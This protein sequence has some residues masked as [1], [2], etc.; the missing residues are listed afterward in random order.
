MLWI[1]Q[2]F[3]PSCFFFINCDVADLIWLP[4]IIHKW[5]QWGKLGT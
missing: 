4:H 1:P 2:T 3:L 5:H